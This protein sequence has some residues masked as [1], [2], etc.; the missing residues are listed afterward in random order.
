MASTGGNSGLHRARMRLLV[1]DGLGPA[2]GVAAAAAI[3]AGVAGV[4]VALAAHAA[5]G[6]SG[7]SGQTGVSGMSGASGT[8]AS[9]GSSG[10]TAG[11]TRVLH[12]PP[13]TVQDAVAGVAVKLNGPADANSPKPWFEPHVAGSWTV[14][15]DS[16]RF[17]PK[18]TLTPCG[19]YEM[20]IPASTFASGE[21]PLG[22]ASHVSFEV[23]CPSITALQEALA[24]LNYLP[25]RLT[26]YYGVNLNVPLTRALAAQ[27]AYELPH[28]DLHPSYRDVPSLQLG[29]MD[30]TTTG[31]LEIYDQDHDIPLG[32][33]PDAALW[34]RLIA[35]EADNY[36]NPR[37]YTWVTVTEN[38]DPELL[39]VHENRRIVISS[40]TNTGV[41]G[42]WTQTGDF[43][44]YVRYV[45]TTMTGT[46]PDGTHYSDPGVPWVNYFNGGDAVHGFPRASYGTPQSNGCV[47]L[48]IPTAAMVYP[49]LAVGDMVDISD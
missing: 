46:N 33:A 18:V 10:A 40:P 44:I 25:Y 36:R 2:L 34:T 9:S 31:A 48:P 43:A 29:T 8:T 13:P 14:V 1:H 47:E 27:R 42:A 26:S 12:V 35:E 38:T 24:R 49:L 41:P 16:E 19:S 39:E 4:S 23:A 45:S 32:T 5:Q 37:P 6:A 7:Q 28:G 30:P 20:T 22:S 21:Q 15:G 17:T 3:V 11:Q